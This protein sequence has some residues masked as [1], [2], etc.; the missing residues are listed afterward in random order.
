MGGGY[1]SILGVCVCVCAGPSG[2]GLSTTPLN[3][4]VGLAKC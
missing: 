2:R 3:S 1:T 4:L